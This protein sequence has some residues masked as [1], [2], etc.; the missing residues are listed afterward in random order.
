MEHTNNNEQTREEVALLSRLDE[1]T[2]SLVTAV[3][4]IKEKMEKHY[5]SVNEFTPVKNL[6][7][8]MVGIILMAFV[9]AIITLVIR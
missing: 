9:G 8:G 4:D 7:Y 1:R 6:V 2:A 5:V 3:N